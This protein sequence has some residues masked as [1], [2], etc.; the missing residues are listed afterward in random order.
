[1][2]TNVTQALPTPKIGELWQYHDGSPWPMTTKPVRVL[3]VLDGW[4]RYARTCFETET[5]ERCTL[6]IFSS[7]Y[8][9]FV[10]PTP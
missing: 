7:C 1:M 6:E 2:D 5:D 4:V 8:R 3:D 9:P 10:E